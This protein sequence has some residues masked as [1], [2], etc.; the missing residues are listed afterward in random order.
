LLLSFIDCICVRVFLPLDVI[1]N[2]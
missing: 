1:I 2:Q